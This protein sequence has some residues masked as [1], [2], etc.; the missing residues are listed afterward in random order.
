MPGSSGL[1]LIEFVR[2]LS[3]GDP[4][5]ETQV[6]GLIASPPTSAEE[7]GFHGLKDAPPEVRV[8]L[9][10]VQLLSAAG[11][12]HSFEDKYSNEAFAFWEDEGWISLDNLPKPTRRL[13]TRLRDW[14]EDAD[15]EDPAELRAIRAL[16]WNGYGAATAALEAQFEARGRSLV[17]L[18]A[19]DGDTTFFAA[20][21]PQVA[22]RW[23]GRGFGAFASP[24]D[25]QPYEGG[26]RKPMWDRFF[27]HLTYA[28]G[29]G[30]SGPEEVRQV[31]YPPGTRV[32]GP[33]VRLPLV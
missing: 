27:D 11:R 33:M 1:S 25:K 4:A 6:Q 2:D 19:T 14:P 8:W 18:D 31:G 17:S 5:I 32:R 12:V 30:A 23:V 16:L 22:A 9:A 28:V 29:L 7:I 21:L 13:L 10:T 26:V 20:V 3:G 24:F 15:E